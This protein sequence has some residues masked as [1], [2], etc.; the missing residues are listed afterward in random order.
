MEDQ[1]PEAVAK[2]RFDRLLKEVQQIASE[3]ADL[4]TGQT[5]PVLAEEINRQDAHLLTGRLSN[6]SVVHFPGTAE[7]IGT[8]RNVKLVTCKGFYY[9]GELS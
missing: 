9:L 6:N 3:K 2:E 8:I 4:L 1:I 7:M 5:L